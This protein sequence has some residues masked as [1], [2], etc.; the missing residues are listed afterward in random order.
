MN[1]MK[2]KETSMRESWA[3]GRD[4]APISFDETDQKMTMGEPTKKPER[5]SKRK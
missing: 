5:K 4:M 3:A 1:V 2:Q